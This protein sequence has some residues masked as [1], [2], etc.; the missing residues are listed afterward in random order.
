MKPP[1]I[2]KPAVPPPARN[3]VSATRPSVPPVYRPAAAAQM[4]KAK[5]TKEEKAISALRRRYVAVWNDDWY[6]QKFDDYKDAAATMRDIEDFVEKAEASKRKPAAASKTSS[7]PTL[8]PTAHLSTAPLLSA[9]LS[10]TP[11]S[12]TASPAPSPTPLSAPSPPSPL[13]PAAAASSSTAS[14]AASSSATPSATRKNKGKKEKVYLDLSGPPPPL[15]KTISSS[16]SPSSFAAK[17]AASAS[18]PPP[19][20]PAA[21][22]Q[23]TYVDGLIDRVR[24][25][26]RQSDTGSA[27]SLT[28]QQAWDLIQAL[29]GIST[30]GG[31]SAFFVGFSEGQRKYNHHVC[32]KAIAGYSRAVS[33]ATTHQPTFHF[34]VRN[35]DTLPARF[36]GYRM[37]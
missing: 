8:S 5:N 14:A 9:P 29:E 4:Y 31:N 3:A 24:R 35:H 30:G 28:E 2:R 10:S 27:V 26:D 7:A 1:V 34:E 21:A 18:L 11:L 6:G 15:A 23:P 36:D 13:T 37:Q 22:P 32:I 16:S 25:W 12:S 17:A 33:Q 19:P 20:S